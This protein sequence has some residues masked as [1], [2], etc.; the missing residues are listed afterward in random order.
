MPVYTVQGP[1]GKTYDIEGPEGA[2]VDDLASV[3]QSN[4]NTVKPY[5]I[6]SWQASLMNVGNA[7][8]FGFG[9]EIAGA[10][11][12]AD[13]NRYRATLDQFRKDY[14]GSALLGTISG[15]MLLP[16]GAAKAPV[17]ASSP[18]QTA[19]G[20]G[21]AQ[22]AA[23]AAGD[24][25]TMETAIP[26]AAR[27]GMAGAVL[28]PAAMMGLGVGGN[29]IGALKSQMKPSW[30]DD[31]ARRRIATAFERDGVDAEQV[32]RNMVELGP[33]AR[34]ADGGGANT[35]SA[36]DFNAVLPGQTKEQL[37]N[38]IR[39]RQATRFNRLDEN[40]VY[41]LNGGYGRAGSVEKAL[42]EQQKKVA[43]PL[44]Q[45]A[46]SLSI[47]ADKELIDVLDAAKKLGAYGEAKTIATAERYPFTLENMTVGKSTTK[48]NPLT[49]APEKVSGDASRLAVRD[50]DYVK[51]GLDTLI[52]RETNEFG[53]VSSKGR[54][55]ISLKNELLSKVDNLSPEFAAARQA[56]AGPAAV[57]SAI[58]RGKNFWREEPV[59]LQDEIA[60]MT[61]S[62]KQAFKIGAA[63]GLRLKIGTPGGQ[64]ELLNMWKNNN[65]QERLKAILGDDI[66]YAQIVNM[67]QNEGKLKSLE[68]LGRGSQTAQ[69][70]FA[71]EDQGL[72]VAADAASMGMGRTGIL[73]S[74]FS[75][76]KQ[77]GPRISTPEPV[78]DSMGKILLQQYQPAEMQALLEAQK[79]IRRQRALAAT[80]GGAAGGAGASGALGG[81]LD[82]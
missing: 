59:R 43:G 75:A 15:S 81:L 56:F 7:V 51:R 50:I 69:R 36:L 22:A 58:E 80:G 39:N 60:G 1:D 9:D 6:P 65:T 40:V 37:E 28:G 67:I 35:R 11:G 18:W 31:I 38:V 29:V 45:K 62:E 76:I 79:L 20:V 26:R 4:A 73:D 54:A 3:I 42:T 77:N 71:N 66:K 52:E 74:L 44:Y 19:A 61:E 49:M 14:P 64:T 13:K 8:S 16:F 23:Q 70:L 5:D 72:G 21:M 47:D 33:E 68:S 41:A 10:T 48:T 46:H 78:R 32:G 24:A 17:A 53:K 55:F 34:I 30:A 63:E 2:S 12:L 57:K 27:D 82:D 25:P